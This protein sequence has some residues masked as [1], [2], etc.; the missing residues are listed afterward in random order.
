MGRYKNSN[1]DTGSQ[2]KTVTQN[3]QSRGVAASR[4]QSNYQSG[5]PSQDD[6]SEPQ[7]PMMVTPRGTKIQQ[8][9]EVGGRS[10]RSYTRSIASGGRRA[11]NSVERGA[12]NLKYRADRAMGRGRGRGRG[13]SLA[14]PVDKAYNCLKTSFLI[15][16][17]I[18]FLT[19]LIAIVPWFFSS[20]FSFSFFYLIPLIPGLIMELTCIFKGVNDR[21]YRFIDCTLKTRSIG[22]FII[23][24]IG[25]I[26]LIVGLIMI[27]T[28]TALT[29]T[30]S[31][32]K[33]NSGLW[34]SIL[35]WSGLIWLIVGIIT[36]FVTIFF[37]LKEWTKINSY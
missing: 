6:I 10:A 29:Y 2:K 13:R 12:R 22:S 33:W 7:M 30:Y 27:I 5:V 37:S 11:K 35:F 16:I 17:I 14:H 18:W 25:L 3:Y 4:F 1:I 24:G 26:M 36:Y 34:A 21:N 15:D 8:P 20:V 19:A 32:G 23:I 31:A 28:G 9:V